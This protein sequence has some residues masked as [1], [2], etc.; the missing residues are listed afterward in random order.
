[1]ALILKAILEGTLQERTLSAK[2]TMF[3]LYIFELITSLSILSPYIPIDRIVA[4]SIFLSMVGSLMRLARVSI[5]FGLDTIGPSLLR[6]ESA[7][8]L[9]FEWLGETMSYRRVG[10]RRSVIMLS[11]LQRKSRILLERL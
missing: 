6:I 8:S 4:M 3:S 2:L 5:T 1:M 11:V 7:M 10:M 9:Y